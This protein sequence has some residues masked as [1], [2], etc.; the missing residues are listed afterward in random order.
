MKTNIYVLTEDLNFFYRLNKELEHLQI[1]FNVL[2]IRSKIPDIPNSIILTT[3]K[4][5]SNFENIDRVKGKILSYT[6]KEDFEQYMVKVLAAKKIGNIKY[7]ELM[8][9]IDPGTKHLGIVIYLNDFY[10]NSHT[11]YIRDRFIEKIRIYINA[12]QENNSNPLKLT[13][14]FGRGI[15]PITLNLIEQLFINI[16]EFTFRIILIDES[17]TSK[18]KIRDENRKKIPKDEAAA[19]IISLRD[20]YEI[21][22]E[23]YK[24]IL[25]NNSAMKNEEYP[26]ETA[27]YNSEFDSKLIE[28]AEAILSGNLSLS[29]SIELLKAEKAS[30]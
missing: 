26:G 10:L 3:M 17:K 25:K 14:K 6:N 13:F 29:K 19:L 16:K 27:R 2:N 1:K 30:F 21:T 7:S 24:T 22:F 18:Y 20:G 28:I 12:L 5:M 4:E 9:S 11:I 15:M 8:F 23:N